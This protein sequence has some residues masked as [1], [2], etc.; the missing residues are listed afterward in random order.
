M[1]RR[2]FLEGGGLVL[3][4]S[5][6][7]AASLAGNEADCNR[8]RSSEDPVD[9]SK[10]VSLSSV[11]EGF[12]RLS[13]VRGWQYAPAEYIS[14]APVTSVFIYAPGRK[15][16]D[17]NGV[18]VISPSVP[19]VSSQVGHN[20]STRL[21]NFRNAVG[22]TDND[23]AG[24]FVAKYR[25]VI[26][27][28]DAGISD[29]PMASDTLGLQ[30]A[31][32]SAHAE[33]CR[34]VILPQR[35]IT[36]SQKI[37][38]PC[39]VSLD[40]NGSQIEFEISGDTRAF[41]LSNDSEI[42]NGFVFVRGSNPTGRGDS[43]SAI[44][45]G[46]QKTGSGVR[47]VKV[48]NLTVGTNRINGNGILFFGEC[49]NCEVSNIYSPDSANI[50]RVVAFEWG[51]HFERTGHP[52]NNVIKNIEVGA[53]DFGSD[54][55]SNAFVV[56]LSS[57]F[58]TTVENVYADSCFGLV[59]VATGDESNDH[60][61]DRYKPLVGQGI[62]ITNVACAKVRKYGVRVY[63]KGS[64]SDAILPQSTVITNAVL[65]SDHSVSDTIGVSLE[66]CSNV[67][68]VNPDISGMQTGVATG[69]GAKNMTI[70]GGKIWGNRGSGVRLGSNGGGVI[71][72]SIQDTSFSLNNQAQYRGVGGASAIF[73]QNCDRWE[74]ARC[75]FGESD[76][77]TQQYSVRIENTA[78]KGRMSG[79]H[80][81]SL[82]PG[83][84]AY[85]NGASNNY[86]LGTT[87][88][89]NT[90]DEGLSGFG[91]AP[92]YKI[93]WLGRKCFVVSGGGAPPDTGDWGIGDRAYY[94]SPTATGYIGSVYTSS[95]WKGFGQM[96]G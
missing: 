72:C 53:L 87:G 13:G 2:S 90:V 26:T 8:A 40:L 59:G 33:G 80:T 56:W 75:K 18:S 46:D 19:G 69:Q 79:N 88:D 82:A 20:L 36:L 16:S 34:S 63:G 62:K 93:D 44:S 17:H 57:V 39:G 31:L 95:G 3:L 23:G 65:R 12:Y 45:A 9:K 6:H 89:N 41:D 61:P 14:G 54:L 49:R 78:P 94:A 76:S 55:G 48:Y 11:A 28:Y 22:E 4:S 77:E 24:C 91:G 30:L 35:K 58:N 27:G 29:T 51:G 10:L 86:A 92:V 15:K 25:P 85:V 81:T 38:V 64:F 68:I 73:I 74:V 37:T 83:G 32:A 84:V 5:M 70:I 50:G 43:H 21:D 96:E 7:P 47:G 1:N 60:S 66:F 67:R 42:H 52:H 71:E